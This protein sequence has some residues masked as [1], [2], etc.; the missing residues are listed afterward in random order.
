MFGIARRTSRLAD[1]VADNGDNGMVGHASFTRTVVVD[2]IAEPQ[3]ALL[4]SPKLQN[5]NSM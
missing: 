3:R 4:H 2:V 5:R 1:A